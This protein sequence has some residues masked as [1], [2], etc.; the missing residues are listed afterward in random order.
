MAGAVMNHEDHD[1]W[2]PPTGDELAGRLFAIV[3]VGVCA[4]IVVMALVGAGWGLAA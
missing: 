1:E 3:M 2:V 4:V